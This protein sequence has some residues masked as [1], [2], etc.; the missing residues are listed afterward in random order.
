MTLSERMAARLRR[1]GQPEGAAT[2][3][4][5]NEPTSAPPAPAA[6]TAPPAPAT[7]KEPLMTVRVDAKGKIFTDIIHKERVPSLIQTV[8]N[9]I[10]GDIF[11]RPDQRV[12]DELNSN[13]EKFI[14][15]TDVEIYGANGQVLYR[16]PF[17][18]LNKE[19]VIWIRP[20]EESQGER[21]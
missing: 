21:N 18:T 14:A 6:V 7:H 10:H 8:T 17:L 20:D 1:T 13:P 12:K 15:V 3:S 19:H 11:M 2:P 9:L 5:A 16:S 4:G